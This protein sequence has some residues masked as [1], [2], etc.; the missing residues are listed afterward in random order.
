MLKLSNLRRLI[1]SSLTALGPV[2]VGQVSTAHARITGDDDEAQSHHITMA[3]ESNRS[4]TF[5]NKPNQD[6]DLELLEELGLDPIKSSNL[7]FSETQVELIK[8]TKKKGDLDKE[9]SNKVSAKKVSSRDLIQNDPLPNAPTRARNAKEAEAAVA[10]T[11][12]EETPASFGPLSHDPNVIDEWVDGVGKT[13]KS[14]FSRPESSENVDKEHTKTSTRARNAKEAEA[15]VASTLGEG[16]P[17]S[18]GPL[19]HDPNVIDD[20]FETTVEKVKNLF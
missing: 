10:S 6:E 3:R 1:A 8:K 20:M 7:D 2:I 14:A 18:F 17:A 13:I 5:F 9:D 12:G 15:A 11:L 4:E 16:T 19:S